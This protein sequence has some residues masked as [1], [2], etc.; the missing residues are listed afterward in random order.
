M[1]GDINHDKYNNISDYH[2]LVIETNY[3]NKEVEE[4]TSK[5]SVQQVFPYT[6]LEK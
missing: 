6:I 3:D 5:T 1:I 4:E 2:M